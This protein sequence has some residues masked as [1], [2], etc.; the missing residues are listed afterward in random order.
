MIVAPECP[1]S[2]GKRKGATGIAGLPLRIEQ[3]VLSATF[4]RWM[5]M[6]AARYDGFPLVYV[7]RSKEHIAGRLTDL[8]HSDSRTSIPFRPDVEGLR[9]LAV[10]LVIA[11]HADLGVLKGG[12]VGVDIFFVLSGYLI[13]SLITKEISASRSV[14][15]ARFYAR[16]ARRLLPA[17]FTMVLVVCAVEAIVINPLFQASV[18]QAAF[19]TLLYSSNLWFAHLNLGYF[20]QYSAVNPLLHT[21]SLAVEEQFYLI[22]PALLLLLSWPNFSAKRISVALAAIGFGSFAFCVWL[23]AVNPVLAF[24]EV[25]A[26]VWEFGAGGLL[27]FVPGRW[28]EGRRTL[29]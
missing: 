26:R 8:D 12:F 23:T 1:G 6:L 18:M 9:A 17:A 16:R 21:W 5:V 7:N 19:A 2:R 3:S 14:N 22:W 27:T 28:L 25:P 15:F 11:S 4:P 13:T 24:F 29:F 10:V 20:D